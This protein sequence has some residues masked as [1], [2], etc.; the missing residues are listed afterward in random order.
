MPKKFGVNTKKEEAKQKKEEV[1]KEKETKLIEKLEN[2]YWQET[3]EKVLSKLK[4]AEEKEKKRIEKLE[5]KQ[6]IKEL[7]EKEEEES[8]SKT[9]NKPINQITIGSVHQARE[10]DL[11]KIAQKVDSQKFKETT[12]YVQEQI[13]PEEEY[14]NTNFLIMEE[15]QDYI[16]NGVD[17]IEGSGLDHIMNNLNLTE[18]DKHPEKR[19]KAAWKSYIE[20][21]YLDL[22]KQYPKFKRNKLLDMLSK[23]F[24]KSQ[25]NPMYVYKIQKQKEML[26]QQLM[27]DQFK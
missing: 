11:K 19:M 21:N 9:K 4:R 14:V 15:Y 5:K 10:D 6:E 3:D 16:K 2:D 20:K 25:D 24:H 1:K 12:S 26:R 8:N 18:T 27:N 13:D 17:L 23:D 22:K 7:V